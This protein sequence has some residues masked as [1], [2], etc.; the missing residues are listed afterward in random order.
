MY[1][2]AMGGSYRPSTGSL[3]AQGP[4]QLELFTSQPVLSASLFLLSLFILA[5]QKVDRV[6]YSPAEEII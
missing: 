5:F 2:P 1:T 4:G 3:T 6:K